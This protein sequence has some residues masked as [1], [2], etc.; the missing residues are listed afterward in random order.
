MV[1]LAAMGWLLW[2]LDCVP[3]IS[4]CAPE[5]ESLGVSGPDTSRDPGTPRDP[6]YVIE[7]I[8]YLGLER[9]ALP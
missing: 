3:A 7:D 4:V 6:S 1:R 5:D 8:E 9:T 2:L